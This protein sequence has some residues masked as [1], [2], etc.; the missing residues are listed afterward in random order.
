M[1]LSPVLLFIGIL[2]T[3]LSIN[4]SCKKT[5]LFSKGNLEFSRDTVVFDTVFTTIGSTT[6]QLKIYNRESNTVVINEVELMGGSS[7]PFG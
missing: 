5:V 4:T 6:Q 2:L 7:S 1:R 3:V